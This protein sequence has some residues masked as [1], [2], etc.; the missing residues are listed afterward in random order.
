MFRDQEIIDYIRDLTAKVTSADNWR[1]GEYTTICNKL[2][3]INDHIRSLT[4]KIIEYQNLMR[5]DLELKKIIKDA[6]HEYHQDMIKAEV[7]KV[8]KKK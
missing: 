7:K 3:D 2:N 1:N 5:D 6:M 8:A 4:N